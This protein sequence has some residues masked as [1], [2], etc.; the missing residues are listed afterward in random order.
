[1]VE[2][3]TQIWRKRKISLCAP[4]L[5]RL[6]DFPE[7]K[8]EPYQIAPAFCVPREEVHNPPAFCHDFKAE[9]IEQGHALDLI[10]LPVTHSRVVEE[11]QPLGRT[12]QLA[13]LQFLVLS[14]ADGGAAG[15][16]LFSVS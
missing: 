5:G 12:Q 14:P 11:D 2:W 10:P 4:F 7:H 15:E 9:Q 13:I 16:D 3:G 1:M 6:K 8:C